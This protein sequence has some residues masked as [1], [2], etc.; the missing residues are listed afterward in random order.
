MKY[1]NITTDDM[2]NGDGLRTVLWLSGCNHHCKNCHNPTTWDPQN[3]LEF[4]D[5]AA[6]ELI[7]KLK[8]DYI[9]GLTISGGDPLY[10]DNRGDLLRFLVTSRMLNRDL[11][12]KKNIWMYTGYKWEELISKKDLDPKNYNRSQMYKILTFIDVLVDGEY[13]EDL[14]NNN[15]HW[16]GSTNQRVI[17]VQKSIRKG[18]VVI[19][20]SN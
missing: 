3:G 1:H 7:E 8:P 5:E 14:S 19:Y 15:Y 2:L 13:K 10:P 9:S 18:E 6:A 20:E 12:E 11:F 16:A 4:S 17:D